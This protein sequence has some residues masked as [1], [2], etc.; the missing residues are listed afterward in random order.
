MS[1]TKTPLA[2]PLPALALA[3]VAI[4]CASQYA[5]HTAPPR[6]TVVGSTEARQS[7]PDPA[8]AE[9]WNDGMKVPLKPGA[10]EAGGDDAIELVTLPSP[11][12]P[13]VAIRLQFDAGS[14]YDP[15]GKEG[16]AALTALM[17]GEAGTSER[18]YAELVD[19]LYPMAA[20]IDVTTDREVSTIPAEVHR[21][22]LADFTAILVEAL[23]R[24]GFAESDFTRHRD[25]LESYLKNTLRASNDEL[26]GLEGLQQVIFHDHPYG[27]SPA[28]SVQSLAAITLDDVKAFRDQ[29]FGRAALTLGI[30]GGYP[31]GY[32]QKLVAA[33]AEM[34]AGNGTRLELPPPAQPEGRDFTLI[35]KSTGSVGIHFGFPLPINRS[36]DDYYPL[37]VA[38]SFLGEHRTFHGRLMQQLRGKRGLNYGDY[39]Y[40]EYWHLPPFTTNPAPNVPRRQQFFSVWVRPVVPDTAHFALRNAIYEVERL[41]EVGMTEEEFE[42]TRSFLV[43]YSKL[44][45][46]TLPN[47]L[48][49]LMDSRFYDMDYY[50]D[51]I[52]QRLSALTVDDV[53]AA[54]RKYLQTDDFEAVF[55]TAGAADVE[56]YLEAG[57]PSPMRYDS[58]PEEE[59]LAAD[60]TIQKVPVDP[61]GFTI[62]A[63]DDMFEKSR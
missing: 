28:G 41:I 22:T 43:N 30:A 57:A 14:I 38:N 51:E 50:I 2:L 33:L 10:D 34:P 1:R 19:A 26:L 37:M 11:G 27:H 63:V 52:D 47:R 32:P 36:H 20:S 4:G 5:D 62:V 23:T 46:Q 56:V 53:N 29:R 8:Q 24:P 6:P 55:V 25:Q 18:S 35:E 21:E 59:V 17:L 49:F 48:G 3:A 13:I 54:V 40:I 61:D 15:A 42:L 16:L 12:S 31:D 44:W 60:K 9:R 58:A 7:A 45:A 39:S